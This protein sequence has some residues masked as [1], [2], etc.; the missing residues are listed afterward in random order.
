LVLRCRKYRKYRQNKVVREGGFIVAM[1]FISGRTRRVGHVTGME[2]EQKT[3]R[4]FIGKS[5][6]VLLEDLGVGK[7]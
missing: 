7:I 6:D 5:E 3:E 2:E 1:T 4:A